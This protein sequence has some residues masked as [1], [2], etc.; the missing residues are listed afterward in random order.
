MLLRDSSEAPI[1]VPSVLALALNVC[2]ACSSVAARFAIWGFGV[3]F[4][5]PFLIR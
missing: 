3:G 1:S 4:L 2:F 5:M